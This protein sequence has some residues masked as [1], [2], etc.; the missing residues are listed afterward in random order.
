M[1][2]KYFN[3]LLMT[4]CLFLF[5]MMRKEVLATS[6]FKTPEQ[7]SIFLS[8]YL[9]FISD[10]AWKKIIADQEDQSYAIIKGDSLYKISERLFKN[11]KY[12]P[13]IW[14]LNNDLIKNPHQIVPGAFIHFDHFSL[15]LLSLHS[16][17][18]LTLESISHSKLL[19]VKRRKSIEWKTL[20]VQAWEH[21]TRATDRDLPA[22]AIEET[23]QLMGSRLHGVDSQMIPATYKIKFL[24]E[25]IGSFADS[26]S[27]SL[28]QAISIRA[29]RQD[30]LKVGH[31][32]AITQE[33]Y[34]LKSSY[35][36]RRGY[37]Y[38]IIG[39][40]K[41][42]NLKNNIAI[43]EIIAGRE[44][45]LRGNF[46]IPLP[47][48]IPL[49]NPIA[50]PVG[51]K[52][53]LLINRNY[54]THVIAQ[55]AVAFIDRGSD[56]AILPGMLF[57]I[58]KDYDQLSSEK[59]II[60]SSAE[61]ADFV[62]GMLMVT[63][64]SEEFS[65]VQ[66]IRSTQD[67][68][69]GSIALGAEVH[70]S[71]P[72]EK[73]GLL[74]EDLVIPIETKDGVPPVPQEKASPVP[75]AVKLL[76]AP[77]VHDLDELEL[78]DQGGLSS[79]EEIE[80]KQLEKWKTNAIDVSPSSAEH[81]IESSA[82]STNATASPSLTPVENQSTDDQSLSLKPDV[83]DRQAQSTS[84]LLP[85]EHGDSQMTEQHASINPPSHDSIP[86]EHLQ[87]SSHEATPLH[88]EVNALS[89]NEG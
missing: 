22:I 53:S 17:P 37:S 27:L 73:I 79:S 26:N 52:C 75:N 38:P 10:D 62:L 30:A 20:P 89:S 59:L 50:G 24:G 77:S 78:K 44:P 35:L 23:I 46:L 11:A 47:D 83:L 55:H 18:S 32:Y 29:T 72:S 56:D 4:I 34:Y 58:Y 42:K 16:G 49:L 81:P 87:E 84:H 40:V 63:Q 71:V 9:K 65:T 88:E 41:I 3:F 19:E 28:S 82:L 5:L 57:K 1:K 7:E 31:V 80:L 68:M 33:P 6:T 15:P 8:R 14:A 66:V 13:K 39:K 86:D 69:E 45:I 70:T 36:S 67:L 76:A 21:T 61:S 12:W 51:V 74:L 85:A 43:G 25:I 64:T 60:D 48:R 2:V 54:S